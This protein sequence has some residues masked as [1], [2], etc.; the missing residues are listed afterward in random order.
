MCMEFD[1]PSKSIYWI[2]CRHS[3]PVFFFFFLSLVIRFLCSVFCSPFSRTTK[4]QIDIEWRRPK[5]KKNYI[6]IH[7]EGN[8]FFIHGKTGLQ[9]SN[10]FK[11][12]NI[13]TPSNFKQRTSRV[14][15]TIEMMFG[16]LFP[17][18]MS[19]IIVY[20]FIYMCIYW[21]LFSFGTQ[22]VVQF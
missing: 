21:M 22:Q 2:L 3:S 19:S 9:L 16:E 1:I 20:T 17:P 12:K 7:C 13:K 14:D 10:L 11:K 15:N 18:M 6:K 4:T 8:F 5:K